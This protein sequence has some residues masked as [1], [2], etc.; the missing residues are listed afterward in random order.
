MLSCCIALTGCALPG[1][2]TTMLVPTSVTNAKLLTAT[3]QESG[4]LL[5][6]IS[7]NARNVVLI[8]KDGAVIAACMNEMREFL[9]LNLAVVNNTSGD[10]IISPDDFSL[11]DARSLPFR[12]AEP[13]EVANH[14]AA[15]V[16]PS[17]GFEP[18]E[19]HSEK[20]R[21]IGSQV[22][23]RPFGLRTRTF[24]DPVATVAYN[25]AE[26]SAHSFAYGY[27][28]S[29]DEKYMAQATTFFNIG[30]TDPISIP[31]QGIVRAAVIWKKH[32]KFEKPVHLRVASVG[33]EFEFSEDD[34]V[35]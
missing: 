33:G 15:W 26:Q 18:R 29:V 20:P 5:D 31:P 23:P 1:L 16:K 27:Q 6:T 10:V 25:L 28:R 11:V 19:R 17:P 13:H 35:K 21:T 14:F 24:R 2:E 3:L 4:V 9:V 34:S 8:S 12:R 32:K 30:L 22:V 7:S